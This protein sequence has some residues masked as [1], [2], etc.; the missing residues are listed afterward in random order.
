M[1]NYV[2]FGFRFILYVQALLVLLLDNLT[3]IESLF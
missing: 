1:P 3:S 2:V